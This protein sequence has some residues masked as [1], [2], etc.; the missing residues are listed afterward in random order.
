MD[1]AILVPVELFTKKIFEIRGQ[2]VML[3]SDLAE[4]YGVKTKVFNQS[5][6]RNQN[7]FPEDFRF[8]LISDEYDLLKSQIVTSKK[9]RGGRR[10]YYQSRAGRRESKH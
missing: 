8:R 7:R 6:T 2:K 10:Y 3:D 1:A 4:L 9:G 5:V